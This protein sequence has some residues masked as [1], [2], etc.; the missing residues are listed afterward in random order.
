MLN[1]EK[2]LKDYAIPYDTTINP[3]WINVSC[4]FCRPRDTGTHLGINPNGEYA[5]CWKCGGHRL[6]KTFMRL[7]RIDDESYQD[8][9]APYMTDLVIRAQLNKKVPK[10]KN[11]DLP[12]DDLNK[13]ERQY[14]RGRGFDPD[15]LAK[16]YGVQGGGIAGDWAYRIIIPIFLN[17]KVVSF[18][19]RDI[20]GKQ[21]L[22]YRTLS[23]EQSV[24]DPKTI[25]YNL[26]NVRGKRVCVI[27]GPTDVWRMGDGFICSLG[28]SMTQ[29]QIKYLA[30]YFEEV[31]FM[32]DP[33]E[34]A[35][36][37][38]RKYAEMLA[39]IGRVDTWIADMEHDC[40]PGDLTDEQAGKL[41]RELGFDEGR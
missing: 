6:D 37:K 5:N 8:F 32:F 13:M 36:A 33:E 29:A 35:Q 2:I 20:T 18:T 30:Q 3:G 15:F 41:R 31:I 21:K 25:F 14:L 9:I 38:A 34:Q 19:A 7:L 26:D 17:H 23:I 4:P 10:A 39:S 27:E 40:D 1:I 24:V 28:T 11:V 12:G 22:R 16:K